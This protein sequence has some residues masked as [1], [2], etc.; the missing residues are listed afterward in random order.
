MTNFKK[1]FA[2]SSRSV[3]LHGRQ[4]E[5]AERMREQAAASSLARN[6]RLLRRGARAVW[7]SAVQK[8]HAP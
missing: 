7:R 8:D 6:G 4:A 1:R 5:R 2:T 3:G